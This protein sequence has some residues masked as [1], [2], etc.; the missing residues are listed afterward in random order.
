MLSGYSASDGTLGLKAIKNEGGITFAQ[1]KTAA[2]DSMPRNAIVAGVVDFVLSSQRIAQAIASIAVHP[3][4]LGEEFVEKLQSGPAMQ[5]LMT[6]LRNH[7]GVDFTQYKQ[8]TIMR[9]LSRRIVIADSKRWI[10]IWNCFS[11]I[12]GKSAHCS[13]ICS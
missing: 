3:Y 6:V 7:A 12:P 8:P 9:R 13:T 10:S 5:R 2:F 1:D 4:R 11:R